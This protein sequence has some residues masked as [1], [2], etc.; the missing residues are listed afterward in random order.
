MKVIVSGKADI[1]RTKPDSLTLIA[2]KNYISILSSQWLE[3]Y[4]LA[5]KQG[6]LS[7]DYSFRMP[8]DN[9][10]A[11]LNHD[12]NDGLAKRTNKTSHGIIINTVGSLNWQPTPKPRFVTQRQC[13]LWHSTHIAWPSVTRHPDSRRVDVQPSIATP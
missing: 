3:R 9:E 8:R 13:I 1:F 7:N 2:K 6:R 4:Y 12:S 11:F 10:G 5:R